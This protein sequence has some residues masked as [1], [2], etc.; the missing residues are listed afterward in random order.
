MGFAPAIP[1]SEWPQT[2]ALEHAL[3]GSAM[4]WKNNGNILAYLT[5][6]NEYGKRTAV[7]QWLRCCA[8]NRKVAGWIPDAVTG[9][10]H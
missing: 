3:L 9:I 1:A 5:A 2:H 8:T 10:F 7:A 6:V 4:L